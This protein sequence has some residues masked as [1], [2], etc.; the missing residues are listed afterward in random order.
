MTAR[1]AR[2]LLAFA[3]ASLLSV[4]F[5]SARE[6][7]DYNLHPTYCV[8]HSAWDPL[9]WIYKCWLPPPPGAPM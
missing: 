5:V 3:L 8:S 2:F 9:W 7:G 1:R 4:T 6:E